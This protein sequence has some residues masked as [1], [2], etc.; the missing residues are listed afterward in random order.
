VVFTLPH[1][2]APLALQNK[3]QIYYSL[4]FRMAAETL[5]EVAREPQ[6]LGA[7]LGFFGVL[8]TWNQKLLQNPH[9]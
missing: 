7:E 5:L 4:L 9:S 1:Q 6:R 3:D 8:H 2:L